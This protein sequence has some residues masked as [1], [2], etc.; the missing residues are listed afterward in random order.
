L[1]SYY[2]DAKNYLSGIFAIMTAQIID[3]ENSKL[4]SIVKESITQEEPGENTDLY[5]ALLNISENNIISSVDWLE[6]NYAQRP[7]YLALD[8]I[9]SLNLN[10]QENAK[11]SAQK[12]TIL[13]PNDILP[14]MMYIDSYFND[15]KSKEYA[16]EVN[17]YLKV[18][19]FKFDDLYYGPKIVS[20][21]YIQQNL[22]TGR[23]FFL[24]EQL[25]GVLDATAQNPYELT[26]TL[27]LASFY[28][29][30]FEE[31]YTLYNQL[32]DELKIRDANTLFLAAVAS[33]AANHH[34]NATALLELSKMKNSNFLESRY[35]LGLLYLELQNNEG[36]A[37]QLSKIGD[38][39]FVSEFF[40]YEIDLDKLLFEYQH[41]PAVALKMQEDA[42]STKKIDANST[43][44]EDANITIA[45]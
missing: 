14:H 19:H 23:L 43:K 1:R 10:K 27:A 38:N 31:S 26:N 6:N 15:L 20:Y 41:K 7:L 18:Q 12:L 2:L 22:I 36:A 37:I 11:R 25:K 30:A 13:L 42:N 3:K 16:K 44:K 4:L 45:K 9:I 5:K 21:L 40:N 28:D 39:G 34:E 29:K 24:R 32:I 35:A 33:T 17:N 8:I